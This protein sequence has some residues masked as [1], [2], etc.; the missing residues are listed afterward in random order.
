MMGT[1][2]FFGL[3]L[4]AV[5]AA[6][7]AQSG[8]TSNVPP[9]PAATRPLTLVGCVQPD[10]AK[11]EQFTLSDKTGT[12]YR[13]RGANVKTYVWRN[14]RILGGLVPSP[15]LAA[16][17]GAIDQTT[18]AMAYQAAHSAGTSNIEPIEFHVTRVRRLTGSCAP[19][20]DR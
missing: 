3:I 10:R 19:K 9:D 15:N 8:P 5:A 16:Q 14:V 17:A 6:R 1:H 11:P 2:F 18:A 7:G 12:I 20:S 13:L 4:T